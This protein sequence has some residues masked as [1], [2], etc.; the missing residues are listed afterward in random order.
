MVYSI[1]SA[2]GVHSVDLDPK[3]VNSIGLHHSLSTAIADL[4]DNSLDAD[5]TFIQIRVLLAGTAPVGIQVID[6]GTGMDASAIDRAMTYAGT[7]AY[8]ESDLGHFGVGLKAASLS[9]ADTVLICSRAY[10]S[11]TVGRKLSRSRDGERPTVGNL[12]SADASARLDD[13]G[14]ETSLVTGTVVE[15]RDVRT[16]PSTTDTGEQTRWLERAIRETRSHLGL[17]LHRILDEDGPDVVMGTRDVTTGDLGVV[18]RVTAIDPFGYRRTGDADFPQSL[19]IEMT[20]GPVPVR[21][22]AHVWPPRSQ[23]P[24]FKIGGEPG[25]EHQG[26]FV[27]RKDRLLQAG[28]WC[29]LWA[30]RP[31]WELAR[32]EID[33]TATAANH[34]TINPEKS[35]IEFSADLRRAL[36]QAHCR[37]TGITLPDYLTRAA[38]EERI[39]RSRTRQPVTLVEPSFGLPGGVVAAFDE[40]VRF[41]PDYPTVEIRWRSLPEDAVFEVDLES[42][43]LVL[44]VR[45]RGAIVGRRSLDPNDAPLVKSLM[46]IVL[47]KYFAGSHLGD[48]EKREIE[49]WQGILLA[50]VGA[51]ASANERNQEMT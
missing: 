20:N 36:E 16:F 40:S 12:S 8:R 31:G 10:G 7:R 9:Q 45:H 4:V 18:R 51:Q 39:S 41:N 27:Y 26:F 15:W 48:R 21:A 50:A 5:A 34:V 38:A 46:F 6:N 23:D 30:D 44:N 14:I 28:G 17:V 3:L 19:A 49:A 1:P 25:V 32:V 35:G 43:E 47:E 11:G 33:L 24:G 42:Q 2:T 29:G 22:V 37:T 13:A